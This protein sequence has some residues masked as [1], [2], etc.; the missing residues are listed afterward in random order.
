M[1]TMFGLWFFVLP[2]IPG[3]RKAASDLAD[4]NPALIAAGFVLEILALLSYSALTRAALPPTHV[5]FFRLFRIQMS[6]KSVSN[7]VPAGSA[8]GSALGYRLMTLS[9]ISGPDA[10]FALATGGLVSAVVLNL[11]LLIT[12]AISIPIHGVNDFYGR[13]ALIGVIISVVVVVLVVGLMRG[14]ARAERIVR[15]A[16]SRVRIEPDRAVTVIR[17]IAE[18][19]RELVQDRRLLMRLG[20]WAMLNWLLDAG[21]LWVFLRA[22]DARLPIDGLIISFCLANVLAVIP[23]TPGG[24]GIVET[25]L[26]PT[27]TAFG[28][29]RSQAILG[30]AAYRFAQFWFPLALGGVLYLSLRIGPWSIANRD[31]LKPMRTLT[32]EAKTDDT[33][34]IEWAEQYGRR[35]GRDDTESS[36]ASK[37][38]PG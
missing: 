2:L 7:V 10:G 17:R 28:A 3:F 21:A 35:T 14:Q 30:V 31:S 24:L 26:V 37:R 20:G 16:A 34:G 32:E 29:T 12:L 23:L 9:G 13:A 25:V 8:A 6:T 5:S 36:G 4:V 27:L 33:S 18:R 22:F 15:G 19:L 38:P 11:L 1:F